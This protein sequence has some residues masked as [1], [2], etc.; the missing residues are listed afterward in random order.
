MLAKSVISCTPVST[1]IKA[2]MRKGLSEDFL[3][4]IQGE[5]LPFGDGTTS[6][7]VMNAILGYLNNLKSTNRKA[8]YN[9]DF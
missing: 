9:I 7:K 8:F 2:A 4:S 3:N 1:A 5:K 6:F